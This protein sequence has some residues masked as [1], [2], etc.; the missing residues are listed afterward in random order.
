MGGRRGVVDQRRTVSVY[1]PESSQTV[2]LFSE[3]KGLM[4]L[5]DT[6]HVSVCDHGQ[7][8]QTYEH[9]AQEHLVICH[10]DQDI[11]LRVV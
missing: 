4:C 2:R 6:F 1:K 8:G 3:G 9:Q 11:Q 10:P 7:K 5:A